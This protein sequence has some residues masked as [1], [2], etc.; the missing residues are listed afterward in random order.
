MLCP[1]ETSVTLGVVALSQFFYPQD[2]GSKLLRNVATCLPVYG[3]MKFQF[4][5]TFLGNRDLL[6]CEVVFY[7]EG[8]SNRFPRNVV[9]Q[10]VTY[11]LP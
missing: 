9:F 10:D 11:N 8:G 6:G 4:G 2:G 7:P 3:S 5:E 1:S